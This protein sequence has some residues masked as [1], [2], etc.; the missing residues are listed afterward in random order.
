MD[1][2]ANR[3]K[4]FIMFSLLQGAGE[5]QYFLHLKSNEPVGVIL[6][7]DVEK[8]KVTKVLLYDKKSPFV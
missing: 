1:H 8:D 4:Y 7:C 5:D 3:N 2:I 6:L